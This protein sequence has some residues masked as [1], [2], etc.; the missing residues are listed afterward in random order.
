MT[1]AL[2]WISAA[3]IVY[4]YLGY[5]LLLA[6][7]RPLLRRPV[8]AQPIEPTV[9][10][11]VPAHNEAAVIA[12]KIENALA[13]D[14]PAD[15]LDVIVVSDGS[16]DG[17][18][19][20]ARAAAARLGGGARVRVIEHAE[21]R[22][23]MAALNA[24]VSAATGE[25]IVFTD[26]AALFA[27]DAVR[28]LVS[29]YA[30]PDVGAAGGVYRV[31]SPHAAQT[32]AQEDFY[33]KYETLLKQLEASMG[34]VL[35]THGQ[36]SS[37]RRALYPFPAEHLINDDYV[38]PTRVLQ[39]GHRVAYDASA[40]V[41]EHAGEMSGFG[42]RVRIASGNLQQLGDIGAF[43][44]PF[45]PLPL[46]FFIS[47]KVLR[48]AVPFAMVAAAA[49]S[50]ALLNEPLYAALGAGQAVF[51]TLAALG[52]LVQLHPKALRLPYYFCMINAAIL[53][54]ILGSLS[55]RRRVAWN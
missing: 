14:Y 38:I 54:A 24:G 45:R 29:N 36:I 26:A 37:V 15:R 17:T 33:W 12:G 47:H 25:I 35:G 41:H 16:T 28:R 23:K 44:R 3:A 2:F 22:G 8:R 42:R 21:N 48:L 19:E 32:G 9:S 34:S 53:V 11:I 43:V 18:A 7:L 40:V 39:R 55:G 20:E 10:I 50:L 5:P 6:L 27:P 46:L 49:A 13:L 30:D 1:K 51:Y 31:L 52:H 4:T